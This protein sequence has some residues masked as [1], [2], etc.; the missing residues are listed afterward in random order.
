MQLCLAW[1]SESVWTYWNDRKRVTFWHD[2]TASL[3]TPLTPFGSG[4]Q[5]KMWKYQLNII[6]ISAAVTEKYIMRPS[7]SVTG[8]ISSYLWVLVIITDI[9]TAEI[10]RKIN[11]RSV[12]GVTITVNSSLV[13]WEEPTGSSFYSVIV[14][15]I[16]KIN[17]WDF[18]NHSLGDFNILRMEWRKPFFL[19]FCE[20]TTSHLWLWLNLFTMFHQLVPE[21][22][23]V[24]WSAWLRSHFVSELNI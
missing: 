13:N 10:F 20:F 14:S 24:S 2:S 17:F 18:P 12:Q 15:I 22:S 21:G 9:I 11:Q 16:Q 19:P 3:Q 8:L 7:L 23:A 6:V 5:P 4:E 1:P